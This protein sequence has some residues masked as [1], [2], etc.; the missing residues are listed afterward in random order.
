MCYVGWTRYTKGHHIAPHDDKMLVPERIVALLLRCLE[1]HT[2]FG[3]EKLLAA[4][5]TRMEM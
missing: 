2:S 4:T 1:A 3:P 5:V